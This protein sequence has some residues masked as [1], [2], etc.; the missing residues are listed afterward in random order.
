MPGLLIKDFPEH[1]HQKLKQRATQN[2]RSMTKEAL[3]LLER[4]LLE[5]GNENQALP[6]PFQGEFH[7]NDEW[8]DKAKQAGRA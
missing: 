3:F 2:K 1:L 5:N 6:T 7:I 8:L 4:A